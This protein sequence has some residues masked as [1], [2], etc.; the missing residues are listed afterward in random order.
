MTLRPASCNQ[1]LTFFSNISASPPHLRASFDFRTGP[2]GRSHPAGRIRNLR[3][4]HLS[5]MAFDRRP[6]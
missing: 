5:Q 1:L 3:L 4:G 2:C 6:V